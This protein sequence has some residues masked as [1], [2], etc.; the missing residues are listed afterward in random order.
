M[1]ATVAG[2]TG[3]GLGVPLALLAVGSFVRAL[4]TDRGW[5]L[6]A[7]LLTLAAL[8]HPVPTLWMAALV[9]GAAIAFLIRSRIEIAGRALAAVIGGLLLAGLWWVPF[10]LMRGY[11]TVPNFVKRTQFR[12]WLLP[13]HWWWELL[14][15]AVVVAGIVLAARAGRRFPLVLAA[16]TG[17]AGIAFAVA[18]TGQLWNLRLIPFWYFGRLLLVACGVAELAL[19]APA[20]ARSP[21]WA[22]RAVVA[23]P[24]AAL[25]VA[26]LA[27]GSV[28]GSLPGARVDWDPSTERVAVSWLGLSFGGV[29]R[30]GVTEAFAGLQSR[31]D[32]PEL[33]RLITALDR[34][35]RRHGC[36]RTAWDRQ[37]RSGRDREGKTDD[38]LFGGDGALQLMPFFTDGCIDTLDG[39]LRD[40]SATTPYI[41]LTQSLSTQLPEHWV[42]GLPYERF[43][44]A[45]GVAQLRLIG[46]RYYLTRGGEPEAAARSMKDDLTL[47]ASPD[48]WQ[49]WLIADSSIV[50]SLP[51]EP[52]VLEREGLDW[53]EMSA[54]YSRTP[55]AALVPLA[56]DGQ[57]EWARVRAGEYPLAKDLPAVRVTRV[58]LDGDGVSFR[59]SRTGVP[60]LVR[61]S[62]FPGW[63]ADGA[64]GPYRVT[65][66]LMVVVPTETEVRLHRQRTGPERLAIV[67]GVAGLGVVVALAVVERRRRRARLVVSAEA[68]LRSRSRSPRGRR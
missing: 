52:A 23:A 57:A 51:A 1:S 10:L 15:G 34:V 24:V 54:L 18:P 41:Q 45:R 14:L 29:Q 28:W 53:D 35:G 8:A 19:A 31:R 6:A 13:Y 43:D 62:W 26:V 33:Q 17:L 36:G 65:P 32:W 47:V 56:Q 46:A 67:S 68:A 27:I 21:R 20:L 64:T 22:G 48:P 63:V 44:L 58:R 42:V 60:T 40:S 59:V 55:E 16:V 5:P 39:I 30:W 49:V 50:S 25:L 2:E 9:V 12:F 3:Y 37:E 66:N 7:I 61:V 38:L 4:R 11:M